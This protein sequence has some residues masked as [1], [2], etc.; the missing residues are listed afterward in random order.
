MEPVFEANGVDVN[1]LKLLIFLDGVKNIDGGELYS[2][3]SVVKS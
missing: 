2:G 1:L 3:I